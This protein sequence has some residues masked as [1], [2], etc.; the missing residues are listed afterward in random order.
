MLGGLPRQVEG[1]PRGCPNGPMRVP[2]PEAL[3]ESAS[4]LLPPSAI[5]AGAAPKIAT[6]AKMAMLVLL[7]IVCSIAVCPDREQ[8]MRRRVRSALLIIKIPAFS[9]EQRPC[10]PPTTSKSRN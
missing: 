5:A 8:Q 9:S 6:A 2:P 3:G 7:N 1:P 10:V 4:F